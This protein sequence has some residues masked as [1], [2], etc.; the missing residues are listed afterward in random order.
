MSNVLKI[1]GFIVALFMM[2]SG[3]SSAHALSIDSGDN[4]AIYLNSEG[5]QINAIE[6]FKDAMAD[7]KV[8]QCGYVEAIG[9]ARTGKVTL[10]KVK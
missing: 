8:L 10:K 2:Y 7:K 4:K 6:A 5:K 9:N 1:V 3:F